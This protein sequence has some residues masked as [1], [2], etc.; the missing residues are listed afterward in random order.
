MRFLVFYV[1]TYAIHLSTIAIHHST[2][3]EAF[4]STPSRHALI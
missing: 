2:I 3:V 4:Q 1:Q